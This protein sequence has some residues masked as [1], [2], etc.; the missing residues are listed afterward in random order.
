MKQDEVKTNNVFKTIELPASIEDGQFYVQSH[1]CHLDIMK[2]AYSEML[3]WTVGKMMV[4]VGM[5]TFRITLE[6][7]IWTTHMWFLYQQ[8][9]Q[10]K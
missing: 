9:I 5:G 3:G 2:L 4:S 7:V 1:S 10:A 8:F 6:E